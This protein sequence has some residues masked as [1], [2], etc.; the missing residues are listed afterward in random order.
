[1]LRTFHITFFA[2]LSKTEHRILYG[3]SGSA[4]SDVG[5]SEYTITDEATGRADH[6]T[7]GSIL[8][9]SN[10]STTLASGAQLSVNG[11]GLTKPLTTLQ[12]GF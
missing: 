3:W 8:V 6:S 4:V 10:G 1:M 5:T 7:V 11:V 12:N 2:V 9:S